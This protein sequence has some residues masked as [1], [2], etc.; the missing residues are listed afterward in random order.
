M[1]Q[2]C[3]RGDRRAGAPGK[4]LRCLAEL[5]EQATAWWLSGLRERAEQIVWVLDHLLDL[6]SD[7]SA[8][9]RIDDMYALPAPR[10]FALASRVYAYPGVMRTLAEAEAMQQQNAQQPSGQQPGTTVTEVPSTPGVL[11]QQ[12]GDLIEVAQV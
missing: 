5:L 3:A 9:H 2:V 1:P 7:F 11:S 4:T 8:I 10:F 6:E 12:F